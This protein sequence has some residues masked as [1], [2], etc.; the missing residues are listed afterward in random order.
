MKYISP[1]H[2]GPAFSVEPLIFQWNTM[3]ITTRPRY[4]SRFATALFDLLNPIPY[5]LFVGTLIFDIIYASNADVFWTKSAA[6]LVSAGLIF[7]I[8][9]RFINLGHV[10]FSPRGSVTSRERLDFWF[11][12]LGIIAAIFN[13]FVH[14]RD[15]YGVVPE[16][17]IFSVI[18][19]VCLSIGQIGLAYD[20]FGFKE[21]TRE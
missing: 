18:T 8:V 13:A 20:K 6:W 15:A 1:R 19:V 10:W 16:N 14:S 5:G 4:R 12:L 21:T 9:P 3:M 7:A 2:C 11:N 17:V